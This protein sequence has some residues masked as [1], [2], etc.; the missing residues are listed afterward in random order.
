MR[1]GATGQDKVRNSSLT[2]KAQTSRY[3]EREVDQSIRRRRHGSAAALLA[4]NNDAQP[5]LPPDVSQA[6]LSPPLSRE[7]V[8]VSD[9]EDVTRRYSTNATDGRSYPPPPDAINSDYGFP[10][11]VLTRPDGQHNLP[12]IGSKAT[13][14]KA[15]RKRC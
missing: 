6:L 7:G 11:P 5:K 1:S 13:D 10:M 4:D 15:R 14:Y 3:R 8:G 9:G 12:A 2:S